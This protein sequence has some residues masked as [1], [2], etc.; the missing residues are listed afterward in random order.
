MRRQDLRLRQMMS[1]LSEYHKQ[2]GE[3]NT[4]LE[5][6][7]LDLSTFTKMIADN[8][9]LLSQTLQNKMKIPDWQ[10]FTQI[11]KDIFLKWVKINGCQALLEVL[12]MS[13]NRMKRNMKYYSYSYLFRCKNNNRGNVASYIPQLAKAKS[14]SIN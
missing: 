13:L 3:E 11:I 4:T 1:K 6:L 10:P 5:N 2:N 7:N 12:V 9:V 14:K 8:R